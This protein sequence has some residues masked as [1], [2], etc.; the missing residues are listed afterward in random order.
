MR[1]DELIENMDNAGHEWVAEEMKYYR[2]N[3][4]LLQSGDMLPN[5]ENI[6]RDMNLPM[7]YFYVGTAY[8]VGMARKHD[9]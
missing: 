1:V 2:D 5:F 8:G 7:L 9:F 3:P 6:E 4:E